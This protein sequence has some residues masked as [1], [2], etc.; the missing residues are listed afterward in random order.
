MFSTV[1]DV[2]YTSL[3]IDVETITMPLT[4][5]SRQV[6]AETF[7]PLSLCPYMTASMKSSSALPDQASG[8]QQTQEDLVTSKDSPR[9]IIQPASAIGTWTRT[10]TGASKRIGLTDLGLT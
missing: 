8:F 2:S 1:K 5:T 10:G 4:L 3:Y 9:P 7:N 6:C